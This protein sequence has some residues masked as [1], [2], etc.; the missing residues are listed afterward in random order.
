MGTCVILGIF[1]AINGLYA[2]IINSY[3]GIFGRGLYADGLVLSIVLFLMGCILSYSGTVNLNKNKPIIKNMCLSGSA[4]L[5]YSIFALVFDVFAD[6]TI[7][8]AFDATFNIA[9]ILCGGV[10]LFVS[11][12][13][14]NFS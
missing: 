13:K 5:G 12:R 9:L 1:C 14:T 11:I 10:L 2:I 8:T 4:I 6:N 7:Y 3:E